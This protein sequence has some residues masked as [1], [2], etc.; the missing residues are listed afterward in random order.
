VDYLAVDRR[1]PALCRVALPLHRVAKTS[2]TRP[3]TAGELAT[4]VA[5]KSPHL[6]SSLSPAAA[7]LHPKLSTA[8]REH[9][10]LTP[11]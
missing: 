11:P 1:F 2:S 7:H 9:Y 8:A 10:K 6:R 3:I 4:T 5:T